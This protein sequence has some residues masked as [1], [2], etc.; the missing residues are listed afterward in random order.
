MANDAALGGMQGEHSASAPSPSEPTFYD[1]TEFTEDELAGIDATADAL[2]RSRS[3]AAPNLHGTRLNEAFEKKDSPSGAGLANDAALGGMNTVPSAEAQR[4]QASPKEFPDLTNSDL[5]DVS[6]LSPID[7]RRAAFETGNRRRSG[8]G[9]F[10]AH[11][12]RHQSVTHT[13]FDAEHIGDNL[14]VGSAPIP[15][16]LEDEHI[17]ADFALLGETLHRASPDIAA[18]TRLVEPAVAHLLRMARKPAEAAAVFHDIIDGGRANFGGG[19]ASFVFLPVNNAGTG[20]GGTHWS[21]LFVDLR[22]RPPVAY[23]Y[24]SSGTLNSAIAQGLAARLGARLDR[25]RMAQQDNSYDCGVFVVDATRAL[26]AR[27]AEGERPGS[28]PLHLDTL[29]TDR[30]AL[31]DRLTAPSNARVELASSSRGRECSYGGR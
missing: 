16:W 19:T 25:V 5:A 27:L 9:T 2:S 11:Q 14:Q 1:F 15:P 24:D 3:N 29:V 21:L 30:Q 20:S 26:A 17:A 31:L 13:V 23:H 12:A 7:T 18:Q 8:P 10:Y 22:G 28:Q 6:E 4:S